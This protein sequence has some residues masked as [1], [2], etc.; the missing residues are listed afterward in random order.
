MDRPTGSSHSAF[1]MAALCGVA[2]AAGYAKTN[3]TASLVAGLSI[4]ALYG[5]GGYQ[6]NVRGRGWG[7]GRLAAIWAAAWVWLVYRLS[8]LHVSTCLLPPPT[9]SPQSG[10]PDI[11]HPLALAASIALVGAMAPRYLK[12]KKVRAG[13]GGCGQRCGKV[14]WWN[15]LCAHAFPLATRLHCRRGL[16]V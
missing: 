8:I 4:A 16:R 13:S 11:G 3:S 7:R 6:I 12:T 2:G 1:T 9:A 10:R 14:V 15:P 5:A